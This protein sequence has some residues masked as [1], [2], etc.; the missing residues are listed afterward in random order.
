MSI[1]IHRSLNSK[2]QATEHDLPSAPLLKRLLALGY[3]VLILGALSIAYWAV[4]TLIMVVILGTD[5]H[6]EYLP[7]QKGHW[8]DVG[9]ILTIIGFYWFFW[10]HGGQTI[11]MR[12]WRLKLIS[13]DM[14]R[15]KHSQCLTRVA[16]APL[17]VAAFGLGYWWCFTNKKRATWQDLAS[18]TRV[19]LTPKTKTP[20]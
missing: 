1:P 2:I 11:G 8:F 20:I 10:V 18:R 16:V 15:L 4:A 5:A 7:M 12:A 14:Q 19:V 17:S 3:D 9:W 13:C 6:K